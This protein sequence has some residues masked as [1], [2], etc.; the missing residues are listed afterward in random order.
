MLTELARTATLP[1]ADLAS[2]WAA[3]SASPPRERFA[4]APAA[5]PSPSRRPSGFA[6]SRRAP[7]RP[8]D[9]IVH[10][11]LTQP[12]WWDSL[13]VEDH[14]LLHALPAPHGDLLAWL[15]RDIVEHGPRPWAA[16]RTALA[17]DAALG[18]ALAS[19]GFDE[20]DDM[21]AGQADLRLL[22]DGKLL[23]ALEAR[24]TA[25]APGAAAD[26]LARA[27]YQSISERV[28]MLRSRID[29]N[30]RERSAP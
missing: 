19:V 25:L 7:R 30:R 18:Q 12:S 10:L 22:L 1:E 14:D 4:P 13:T 21:G 27:E 9:R 11:L 17:D 3:P 2:Q 16:V 26:P 24:Q 20:S 15:E 6:A 5:G 23:Q 28:R 8:E 29:T